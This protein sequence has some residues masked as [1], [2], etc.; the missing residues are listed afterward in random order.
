MISS[1]GKNM[2]QQEWSLTVASPYQMLDKLSLALDS[3]GSNAL[4]NL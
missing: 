3:L 4:Y 2:S 1:I